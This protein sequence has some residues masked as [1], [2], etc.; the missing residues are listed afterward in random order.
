MN[1]Y[2]TVIIFIIS[3]SFIV[4]MI[5]EEH[6]DRK[7]IVDMPDCSYISNY[8]TTYGEKANVKY[9]VKKPNEEQTI[10]VLLS[11]INTEYNKLSNLVY[12]RMSFIIALVGC[13]FLWIYC[14][15]E[16]IN[17]QASS[18]IFILV[19]IWFTNYWMRNYLDFHYYKHI[20][21]RIDETIKQLKDKIKNSSK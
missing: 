16:K 1:K 2:I 8:C 14:Y 19:I 4:H 7:K 12:W 17:L 3:I 13:I 15:F 5:Y 18:F 10:E 6:K 11:K 20:Y 21:V 9:I